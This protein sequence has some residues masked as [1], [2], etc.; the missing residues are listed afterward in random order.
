M[1]Q[2][3]AK[4]ARLWIDSVTGPVYTTNHCGITSKLLAFGVDGGGGLRWGFHFLGFPLLIKKDK[5]AK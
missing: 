3:C 2:M 1:A 5:P 4:M